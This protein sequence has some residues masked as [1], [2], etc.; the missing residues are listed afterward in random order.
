MKIAEV[1]RE[2]LHSV[3]SCGIAQVTGSQRSCTLASGFAM[4]MVGNG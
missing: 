4:A 2:Q 1:T 3:K